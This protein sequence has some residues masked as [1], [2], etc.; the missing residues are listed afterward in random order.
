MKKLQLIPLLCF[1]YFATFAQQPAAV[2]QN[3]QQHFRDK[4]KPGLLIG[5]A[6]PKTSFT[7][8]FGYADTATKAML[9]PTHLMMSG[10]TGKIVFAAA[11]LKLVQENKLTLDAPISTYLR[12]EWAKTIPN[13]DCLTVKQLLQHR[14]GLARYIFTSFKDDVKQNPDKVW[15]P[16]EQVKYISEIAPKFGCGEDFAYS[17]TNYIILGAIIE[18]ITGQNLYAYADKQIL[19]PLKLNSFVPTD[20]RVISKLANGYAGNNDPLG[21]TGPALDKTGK[22]RYNL[23][24]EWTGGGYA[25]NPQDMAKLMVA[26]FEGKVFGKEL[27]AQYTATLPAPEVQAEYG[28]GVMKYNLNGKEFYGHSGFFPGY[29]AQVYYDPRTKEAFVFQIN[30]TESAGVQALY[31]GIKEFFA[32]R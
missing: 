3:L 26:I 28:L 8:A 10:S 18:S 1:W 2:Q 25:Y 12:G 24:F 31:N 15:Q 27:L 9:A 13:Y 23:Q 22:S 30:T 14:T 29:I 6:T 5:Y 19:K 32:S 4:A 17:D 7:T 11:A 20:K 21:F 16:L